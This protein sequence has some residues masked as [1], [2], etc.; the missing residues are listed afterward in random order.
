MILSK[1]Y[2][3]PLYTWLGLACLGVL[4]VFAWHF[5]LERVAYL[6][7]AFHTFT[8]IKTERLFI[9]NSRFAAAITQIFP[10]LAIKS[11]VP[12]D[13]VL[14]L[15]SLA[16]IFYYGGV[17]LISAYV[18]RNERVALVIP[19]LFTLLVSDTFY[20]AQSEL[21][22][23]LALLVL[24]YAGV[25]RQAPLQIG[26]AALLALLV[27]A[28]IYCHPL[29]IIPFL[30]LWGYDYLLQQRFRDPLYY[31]LL[32]LALGSYWFRMHNIVPGSYE[33]QRLSFPTNLRLYFPHYLR[34]YSN[35]ELLRLSTSRYC[36]LPLMLLMITIFYIAKR[37]Q[38][39]VWWRLFWV[40]AFVIG[41]TQ[42]VNISYPH[43][44]TGL[45]YIENLYLPLGLFLAVPFA[46]EMLPA[47]PKPR[48]IAAS[49]ALLFAFRLFTIW[50]AHPAYSNYTAWL[51]RIIQHTQSFPEQ[52]VVIDQANLSNHTRHL[53]WGSAYETMLLSAR[54]HPD[55]ARTVLIADKPNMMGW[56]LGQPTLWLSAF[57][58][59]PY[60][61][62]SPR[63]FQ[64]A[65]SNYRLLNTNPP[66]QVAELKQYIDQM[67][68]TTLQ[69]VA[70]LE[71]FKPNETKDIDVRLTNPTGHVLHSGLQ[72]SHPTLLTYRFFST[73]N[74]LVTPTV[75]PSSLEVD[76][77]SVPW[78]Q[79]VRVVAP[80]Y[81]GPYELEILLTSQGLAD[82]PV[83]VR[84]PV[85]V[86]P[87][88]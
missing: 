6:D 47:L 19:L 13:A 3:T 72:V 82:W 52:K 34:L 55:S 61:E 44:D 60:K 79:A 76:V 83:S 24:Y 49:L 74:W 84:V 45:T 23:G 75:S 16:F 36:M 71:P 65:P 33:A 80:R 46:L 26:I 56:A 48:L 29:L 21:P 87:E 12:L 10:L 35:Q 4:F 2:P 50:Q 77:E 62:I 7:L 20:W 41:Y 25:S 86:L 22:Q 53:Y 78:V 70:E 8:Y 57:E 17:F 30:F 68:T 37:R 85:E 51:Q 31:G 59:V 42:V 9:Q 14:R 81:P 18:L 58:Q 69:V 5:Y 28:I 54:N 64:L 11:Q 27:P 66:T 67:R 40:W 73:G 1:R 32:V 38:P 88:S 15:Y 39:L 63:Y 43:N